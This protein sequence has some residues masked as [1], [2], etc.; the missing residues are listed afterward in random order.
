MLCCRPKANEYELEEDG[1]K[2]SKDKKKSGNQ[3]T[4]SDL[5]GVCE[6]IE[7]PVEIKVTEAEPK[8]ELSLNKAENQLESEIKG[9]DSKQSPDEK[10]VNPQFASQIS[11]TSQSSVREDIYRSREKFF[12]GNYPIDESLSQ[13]DR[14]SVSS[15][16]ERFAAHQSKIRASLIQPV[17]SAIQKVSDEDEMSAEEMKAVVNRLENVAQRLESL[18]L[19]APKA[20][21]SSGS[22]P[23]LF[24]H[25]TVAFS[26]MMVASTAIQ[27]FL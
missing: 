16:D 4:N 5:N 3:K 24:F 23:G 7:S 25:F 2:K 10:G 9:D 18:A 22:S 20:A 11:F 6:E 17:L 26:H 12:T 14:K 13:G 27:T 21:G 15:T 1:D 8:L 19:N